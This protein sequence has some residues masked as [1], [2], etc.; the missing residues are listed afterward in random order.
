MENFKK[1]VES[2]KEY[3]TLDILVKLKDS[4]KFIAGKFEIL[5]NEK[6]LGDLTIEK[7]TKDLSIL[8]QK[9]R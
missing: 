5:Y 3:C 8:K 9:I 6:N 7:L 2:A 4:L 1:S